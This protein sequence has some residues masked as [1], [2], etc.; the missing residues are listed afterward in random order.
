MVGRFDEVEKTAHFSEIKISTDELKKVEHI[1]ILGC[2]S[3]YHAGC[4]AASA[5]ESIARISTRAE[6]ASEFRYSSPIIFPNT[7]VIALSQS[8]ETADTIAAVRMMK[9]NGSKIISLCNVANSTLERESD[10]TIYLKAGPEVAVASTKTFTSQ[11]VVLYLL[12]L[13]MARIHGLDNTTGRLLLRKLYEIPEQVIEVLKSAP[14]IEA[15]AGKYA[16][17]NDLFF[18]GRSFLYPTALEAALKLKE[19]AYIDAT[20]YPAGEMKHGPIALLSPEVPVAVLCGN[21]QLQQKIM[22]NL[23]ESKAR[24]APIIAFAWKDF[25]QELLP[26]ADDILWI[27]KTSEALAPILMTIATQLFA[28]YAAKKRGA[29]IDQPRNLAKSVTVE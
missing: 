15:V 12:T 25:I 3:S 14:E 16:H 17:I 1:L 29:P 27:P 18:L 26:V 5:M 10:A 20:G 22:S 2:G 13:M 23:M 11:L 4:I 8:G 21:A 19:V 7:L 28:Y 9:E 24:G 6:I